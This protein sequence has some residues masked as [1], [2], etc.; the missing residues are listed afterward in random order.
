[1]YNNNGS[2]A[3]SRLNDCTGLLDRYFS[4]EWF[5]VIAHFHFHFIFEKSF[6]GTTTLHRSLSLFL[7]LRHLQSR[8]QSEC[9]NIKVSM[10]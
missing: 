5:E 8:W 3:L 10:L 9:L 4:I 7:L 2:Q 6:F 1:M